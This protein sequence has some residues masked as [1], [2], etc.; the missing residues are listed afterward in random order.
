ML[1]SWSVHHAVPCPPTSATIRCDWQKLLFFSCTSPSRNPG[2]NSDE[3][4]RVT[5][6]TD[7]LSFLSTRQKKSRKMS[8]DIDVGG[9]P[10]FSLFYPF[11][12]HPSMRTVKTPLATQLSVVIAPSVRIGVQT[13]TLLVSLSCSAPLFLPHSL[14]PSLSLALSL[15]LRRFA[16]LSPSWLVFCNRLNSFL[17]GKGRYFLLF[18][19]SPL[20]LSVIVAFHVSL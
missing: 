18:W 8:L 3:H 15:L 5:Q 4:T 10:L 14:D 12:F 9:I 16:V 2:L 11:Y 7:V 17:S 6:L 13:I 20:S 1:L 19:C